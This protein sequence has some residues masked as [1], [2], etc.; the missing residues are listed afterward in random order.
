M[1]RETSAGSGC[2]WRRH[3]INFI[4][5]NASFSSLLSLFGRPRRHRQPPFWIFL[6]LPLPP[7]PYA[8]HA[9][10]PHHHGESGPRGGRPPRAPPRDLVDGDDG[11]VGHR[12]C[13]PSS[14]TTTRTD[15]DDDVRD[16]R[17]ARRR[18]DARG[19]LPLAPASRRC[20][21]RE[22]VHRI[23]GGGGVLETRIRYDRADEKRH[24]RGRRGRYGPR[25][26]CY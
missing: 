25:R 6:S 15:R 18:Q 11:V 10:R 3:H 4:Y 23:G 21:W 19:G 5:I 1:E 13:F 12:G 20:G 2:G 26:G 16:G 24:F 17:D 7:T 8:R 9:I 14:A 22:W